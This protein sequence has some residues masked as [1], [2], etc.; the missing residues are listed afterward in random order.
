MRAP[1]TFSVRQGR[2]PQNHK[3]TRTNATNADQFGAASQ[4]LANIDRWPIRPTEILA[5]SMTNEAQTD[6]VR[7]GHHAWS[8]DQIGSLPMY[9]AGIVPVANA[10]KAA[11]G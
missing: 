5:L 2:G 11:G 7:R 3:R 4:T 1:V 8:K 10:D 6:L 9:E